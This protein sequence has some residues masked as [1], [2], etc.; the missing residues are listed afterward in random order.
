MHKTN[1]DKWCL[2]VFV[3]FC[4]ISG[5]GVLIKN[6]YIWISSSIIAGFLAVGAFVLIYLTPADLDND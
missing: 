1:I 5:I 2:N 6:E 3:V 4:W